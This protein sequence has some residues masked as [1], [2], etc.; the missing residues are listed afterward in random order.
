MVGGAVLH[1][2][3]GMLCFAVQQV[4]N[5]SAGKGMHCAVLPAVHVLFSGW[6]CLCVAA[7]GVTCDYIHQRGARVIGVDKSQ[8]LVAE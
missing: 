4:C 3:A 5:A 2:C 7:V 8:Q 1:G 6:T